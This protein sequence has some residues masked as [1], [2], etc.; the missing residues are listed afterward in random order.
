MN[1]EQ[2]NSIYLYSNY[3]LN[4][5][6]KTLSV[7]GYKINAKQMNY[8]TGKIDF[9]IPKTSLSSIFIT[10][11]DSTG[12]LVEQKD[13]FIPFPPDFTR[14][15][16]F[17]QFT[18]KVIDFYYANDSY[19]LVSEILVPNAANSYK[20]YGFQFTQ[21]ELDEN[22]EIKIKKNVFNATYRD[23]K[24]LLAKKIVNVYELAT[25]KETDR[26]YFIHPL[27][28]SFLTTNLEMN[29]SSEAKYTLIGNYVDTK[30]QRTTFF[31]YTYS[32][33]IWLSKELF[34][35]PKVTQQKSFLFG[36]DK[37]MF[38]LAGEKGCRLFLKN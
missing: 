9:T 32:N 33:S 29:T 7:T 14:E 22:Q 4:P 21:T 20:T 5:T 13:N 30:K 36:G 2:P 38:F 19:A 24:N 15:K 17:K 27:Y 28:K 26:L 31:K 8:E 23:A 34:S 37:Q 6:L 3:Y 10:T 25:T 11:L 16:E 12:S 35:E 1:E 18:I